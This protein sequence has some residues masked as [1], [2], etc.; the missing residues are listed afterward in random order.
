MDELISFYNEYQSIMNSYRGEKTDW[1]SAYKLLHALSHR[2]EIYRFR[3]SKNSFFYEWIRRK[4]C[5]EIQAE[6]QRVYLLSK[7]R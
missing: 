1:K 3:Y 2:I 4:L 7:R 6:E 5:E